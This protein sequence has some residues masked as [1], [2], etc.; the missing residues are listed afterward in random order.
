MNNWLIGNTNWNPLNNWG[1]FSDSFKDLERLFGKSVVVKEGKFEFNVAGVPK[2]KIDIEITKDY[3]T[4]TAKS[5]KYSYLYKEYVGGL[6]VDVENIKSTLENG[7]LT[8]ELPK[9]QKTE[10]RKKIKIS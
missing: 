10:P 2:D 9:T 4:V 5:D 6:D 1:G 3:L 8:V 7:I